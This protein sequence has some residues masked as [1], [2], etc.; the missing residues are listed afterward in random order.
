MSLRIALLM[1]QKNERL[2]LDPWITYHRS[3]VDPA[4]IFV[5]DNGSTD[6]QTLAILEAA[7]ASGVSVNRSFN[8]QQDY[9]KC[10]LI[11]AETI[12]Q[13]DNRDPHDFY[14]AMDCDEFLACDQAGRISCSLNDID[15]V[16]AR[17]TNSRKVLTIPH[18]FVNSPYHPNRYAKATWCKK[19]FFAKGACASLEHG[20]HQGRSIAGSEELETGITY[21]EFHYKPYSDH[22]KLSR[23]KI[24]YLIPDLKR[25]TLTEYVRTK[26][27]NFH[28]AIA[29]LQSEYSY[30]HSFDKQ[31]LTRMDRSLLQCFAELGIDSNG[32]FDTGDNLNILRRA[33]MLARHLQLQFNDAAT[34]LCYRFRSKAS[35]IKRL[36]RH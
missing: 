33:V 14:F 7:E 12:K 13:L 25:R 32:L 27:S 18:K 15:Q 36:L 29:L 22:L 1:M 2:L 4:S 30:M 5:F 20:F 19:C 6:S 35:A 31:P 17:F 26:R 3:L 8:Q 11:F 21:I 24:E 16:L 34:S 9:F 28:S 23:Q 10:G